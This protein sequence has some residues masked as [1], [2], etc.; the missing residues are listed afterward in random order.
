MKEITEAHLAVPGLVVLD[1]AALDE[2]TLQAAVQLIEGRVA[3]SDTPMIWR[4]PGEP[5]LRTRV[6]MDLRPRSALSAEEAEWTEPITGEA[7]ELSGDDGGA[8]VGWSDRM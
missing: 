1:V 8:G 3:T 2:D 6:F 4:T 7:P 5:G